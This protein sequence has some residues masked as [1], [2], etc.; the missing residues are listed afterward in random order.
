MVLEKRD[1]NQT[2]AQAG[3]PSPALEERTGDVVPILTP[4]EQEYEIH[5]REQE[6]RAKEEELKRC[7]EEHSLRKLFLHFLFWFVV[8]FVLITL[9]IVAG[10]ARWFHLHDSVLITLLTTTTCNV[11]GC[12]VIAFKWLF[13]VRR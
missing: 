11:I 3:N 4:D 8:A 5:R 6:I 2:L 13:P 1:I 9:V 10:N 7:Q 12:L